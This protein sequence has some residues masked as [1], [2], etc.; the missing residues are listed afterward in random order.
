[1]ARTTIQIQ[2]ALLDTY[3]NDTKLGNE[4]E[5]IIWW[6][7]FVN[8]IFRTP[9]SRHYWVIDALDECVNFA[10]LFESMLAKLDGTIPLRSLITTRKSSELDRHF[11]N[12]ETFQ[13]HYEEISTEDIF[14]D[15]K[16]LVESKTKSLYVEN[17]TEK[18][19]AQSE[20]SFS[21]TVLALNELSSSHGEEEMNQVLDDIPRDMKSLYQ[22]GVHT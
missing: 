10:S 1:M 8:G 4:K 20:G 13:F 9:F 5:R 2:E 21:W 19:L 22:S 12:L 15:I 3:R 18:I 6:K 11:L 14:S 17:E 16:S 7:L